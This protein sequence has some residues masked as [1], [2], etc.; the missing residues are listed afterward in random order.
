MTEQP[1][2]IHSAVRAASDESIDDLRRMREAAGVPLS[3][4]MLGWLEKEL[5]P[6]EVE[7]VAGLAVFPLIPLMTAVQAMRDNLDRLRRDRLSQIAIFMIA[8]FTALSILAPIITTYLLKADYATT[9]LN[10][11]FIFPGRPERL[12]AP[13]PHAGVGIAHRRHHPLDSGPQDGADARGGAPLVIAWLEAHIE[14]GAAGGASGLPQCLD[15]GVGA[16]ARL[17]PAA[18]DDHRPVAPIGDDQR[19]Y[20]GIGPGAPE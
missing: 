1:N 3:L 13:A 19:T 20:G 5:S 8:L 11:I 14:R 15:L 10:N 4:Q 2:A 17:G 9:R 18:P 6:E 12:R 7:E 16:T